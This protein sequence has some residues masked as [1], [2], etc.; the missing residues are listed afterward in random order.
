MEDKEAV[1]GAGAVAL[2]QR[3]RAV[4]RGLEIRLIFRHVFGGSV[5]EIG[6]Q[7]ESQARIGIG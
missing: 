1:R 6:Q 3:T 4:Q 5:G 2:I 7:R